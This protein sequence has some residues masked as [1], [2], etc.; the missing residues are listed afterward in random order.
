MNMEKHSLIDVLI[1]LFNYP[2]NLGWL[3][4]GDRDELSMG[5]DSHKDDP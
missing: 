5:S 4:F 3:G 2:P 1:S